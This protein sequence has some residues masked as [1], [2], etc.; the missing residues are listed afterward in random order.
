MTSARLNRDFRYQLTP[1]GELSQV[2]VSRE[3]A[4]KS[5]TI[6]SERRYVKVYWQVTGVRQDRYGQTYRVQVETQKADHERGRFLHPELYGSD[7]SE[8]IGLLPG[9]VGP[10]PG[11]AA[12][13]A[14]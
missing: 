14:R 8:P 3:V 2:S 12:F 7:P 11:P 10:S 5:F 1:V 13:P 4:D 6:R 9:P